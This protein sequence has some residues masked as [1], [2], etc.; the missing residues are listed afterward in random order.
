MTKREVKL[1]WGTTMAGTEG[2]EV[3]DGQSILIEK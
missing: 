2:R 3:V 1:T